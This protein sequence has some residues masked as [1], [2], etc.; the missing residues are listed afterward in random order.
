MVVRGLVSI[1]RIGATASLVE[2]SNLT[3]GGRMGVNLNDHFKNAMS[4]GRVVSRRAYL[5]VGFWKEA[6]RH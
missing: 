5:H 3:N 2:A 6:E 4:R 1:C